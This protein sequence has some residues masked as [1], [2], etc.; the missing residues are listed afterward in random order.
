MIAAALLEIPILRKKYKPIDPLQIPVSIVFGLF[1]TSCVK[2]VR[3]IPDPTSFA[4]KLIL[5]L[6]STVIVAIGVFLYVSA[7]LIP[8]PTEGFLIAITK[9]TN[10]K[11]PRLKVIGDV[12]MVV[13]SLTTCLIVLHDF[14]SI[15]VGTILSAIL[16]GN[17]VKFY[18]GSSS[19]RSTKQ[20]DRKS[21]LNNRSVSL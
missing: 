5:A 7:E 16:V 4:V 19:L 21:R 10:R 20:W 15:G 11:F 17:E 1:M 8:L 3:L 14:G 2:L 18:P 12:T 6:V 13:I 9:V